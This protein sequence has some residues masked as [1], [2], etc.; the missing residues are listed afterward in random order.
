MGKD[1]TSNETEPYKG[2]VD[3]DEM[4]TSGE[5]A[6]TTAAKQMPDRTIRCAIS[7]LRDAVAAST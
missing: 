2:N 3:V 1:P 4:K 5:D 7:K 6:L